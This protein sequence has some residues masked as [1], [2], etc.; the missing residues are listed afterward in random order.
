MPRLDKYAA[1]YRF[2]GSDDTLLYVGVTHMVKM[3]I[4]AFAAGAI[5]FGGLVGWLG[6]RPSLPQTII[7]QDQ[8]APPAR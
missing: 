4:A 3:V 2:Y 5:L 6:S 1:V 7:I 8:R